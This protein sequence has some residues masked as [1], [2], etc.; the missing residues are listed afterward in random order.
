MKDRVSERRITLLHP[1]VREDFKNFVEDAEE[2]LDIT[3]RIAQGLR[4]IDEQNAL[5][6]QGRTKPGP[7]VT[8]AKG[9]Q[10]YHNYGLAIDIVPLINNGTALDWNYDYKK[11]LPYAEAYGL[12]WGGYFKTI[13]DKPHFEKTFGLNWSELLRRHNN[14]QFVS[15]TKYVKL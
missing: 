10:S 9:G 6:A 14:K 15:G 2:G 8:N 12:S 11:F 5:Y 7:R 1:A 13:V 3:I 4:T